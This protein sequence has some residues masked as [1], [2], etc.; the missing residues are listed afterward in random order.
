MRDAAAFECRRIYGRD[1]LARQ[2]E[3]TL[4]VSGQAPVS[5][6]EEVVMTWLHRLGGSRRG[7]RSGGR[8]EARHRP[9]RGLSRATLPPQ[10]TKT[11]HRDRGAA[12]RVALWAGTRPRPR[13]DWNGSGHGIR[14]RLLLHRNR[15]HGQP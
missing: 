8:P 11:R 3:F 4:D 15:G 10:W 9:V 1:H 5:E 6:W 14:L 13:E 2:Q 7:H 12:R